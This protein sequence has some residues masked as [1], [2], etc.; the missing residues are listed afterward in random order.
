MYY[1][2]PIQIGKVVTQNSTEQEMINNVP[3]T[4]RL[5]EYTYNSQALL[6]TETV[7]NSKGANSLGKVSTTEYKYSNDYNT[8]ISW[9]DDLNLKNMI[10]LPLET[11]SKVDN[12]V[13]GGT[14]V[15]YKT[16]DG[17]TTP[18]E[19]YSIKTTYP[20]IISST[21][22]N[23][24]LP[25]DFQIDGTLEYDSNGNVIYEIQKD[26]VITCY[27]WGYN[28][29]FPIAK[30]ENADYSTVV[31]ALGGSLAVKSF[32]A[33]L[34]PT[35]NEIM[36]FLSPLYINKLFSNSIVTT[37]S[38]DLLKGL[39]S[40][41]DSRGVKTYYFYDNFG[42]LQCMKDNNSNIIKTYDYHHE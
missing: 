5:H 15:K 37:Y 23:A 14:Y 27:I 34:T 42:R 24:I 22:P 16:H 31:D 20:K 25:T 38:Y 33:N 32:G 36:N 10:G 18:N 19:V 41:T 1:F 13:V 26:N 4:T 28:N 29:N 9:I 35:D 6:K 11:L 39:T 17:M 3:T 8:G 21:A 2:Y 40:S 7:T 30:I 12:L